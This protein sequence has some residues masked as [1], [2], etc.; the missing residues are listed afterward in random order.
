M[1]EFGD[2]TMDVVRYALSGLS[3]RT[4]VQA[5][6]LANLNTPLYRAKTVDFE[7]TLQAALERGEVRDAAEPAERPTA[8]WAD[9]NGNTV[10][11]ETEMSGLMKDDLLRQ[12]MVRAFNFKTDTLR[13]AITGR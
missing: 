13:T 7:S 4:E 2:T 11:L 8:D 12:A 10:T 6:N 3:R 9:R 1:V 5:D